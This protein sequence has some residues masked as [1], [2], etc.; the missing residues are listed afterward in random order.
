VRL[1]VYEH[2]IHAPTAAMVYQFRE[3]A[4]KRNPIRV[5]HLEQPVWAWR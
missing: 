5:D 4:L 2:K 1:L 3:V